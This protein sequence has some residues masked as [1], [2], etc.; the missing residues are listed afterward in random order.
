[1]TQY[2]DKKWATFIEKK[3][4]FF[5]VIMEPLKTGQMIT[6]WNPS[7][8]KKMFIQCMGFYLEMY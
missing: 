5:C 4:F 6:K 3:R 1:M 2:H 8:R 7:K